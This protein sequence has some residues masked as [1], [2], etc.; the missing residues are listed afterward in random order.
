MLLHETAEDARVFYA[1]SKFTNLQH[2]IENLQKREGCLSDRPIG[3]VDLK[4]NQSKSRIQEVVERVKEWAQEKGFDAVIWTDLPSKGV[5]FGTNSTG[6]EILPLLTRD[7]TL[8]KNTQ[9]YIRNLAQAPT[10]LMKKILE[11][12]EPVAESRAPNPPTPAIPPK[13][14]LS[15]HVISGLAVALSILVIWAVRKFFNLAN[16]R[17]S[18]P[19]LPWFAHAASKN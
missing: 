10:P 8:L 4:T 5:V 12:S 16:A 7:P 18:T 1:V 19:A 13:V 17:T 2:A 3:Y 14:A 6:E 9:A 15:G 11:R